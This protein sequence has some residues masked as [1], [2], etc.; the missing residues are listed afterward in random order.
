[1]LESF[2][3]WRGRGCRTFVPVLGGDGTK[4]SPP[5]DIFNQ[6]PS[7]I[8]LIRGKLAD[9]IKGHAVL[10]LEGAVL[11]TPSGTESSYPRPPPNR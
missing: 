11:V 10:F 9:H 3:D 5:G 7:E 1:M 4:I 8:S 6:P 2:N